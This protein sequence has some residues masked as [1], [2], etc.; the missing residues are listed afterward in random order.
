MLYNKVYF[1]KDGLVLKKN[2]NN[3][4]DEFMSKLNLK[5]KT[6]EGLLNVSRQMIYKYR[7]MEQLIDLPLSAL[8]KTLFYTNC[9]YIYEFEAL[10]NDSELKTNRNLYDRL[11]TLGARLY[12]KSNEE[13][14]LK[15]Q[16]LISG[17]I[18]YSDIAKIGSNI[19]EEYPLVMQAKLDSLLANRSIKN[20]HVTNITRIHIFNNISNSYRDLLGKILNDILYDGDDYELLLLLSKYIK[21]KKQ[22]DT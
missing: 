12:S 1:G 3:T 17:E 14:S 4:F 10:V 7:N 19:K 21:N 8:V 9:N 22:G 15:I 20:N 2:Y 6:M 13:K 11:T 18:T 5:S 16:I